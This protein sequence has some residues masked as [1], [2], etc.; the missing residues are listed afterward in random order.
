MGPRRRRVAWS[1]GAYRELG[2]AIEYVAEDSPQNAVRLLERL[3]EAGESLGELSE[4]GRVVPE[5]VDP[6]IRELQVDP[7]RLI[8][9]VAESEVMVLGVLHQ[10][11]D[12]D[13]WG[14]ADLDSEADAH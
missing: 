3:L 12:F 8:Y 7:Y 9:S 14:R 6:K 5:L 4:R 2:E 11:R 13:R 10:R 1:A